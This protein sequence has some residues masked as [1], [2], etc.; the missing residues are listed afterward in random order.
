MV[1]QTLWIV[2]FPYRRGKIKEKKNHGTNTPE[3]KIEHPVANLSVSKKQRCQ[4]RIEYKNMF[5]SGEI[6]SR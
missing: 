5:F 3:I 1:S 2:Y 4:T 6:P